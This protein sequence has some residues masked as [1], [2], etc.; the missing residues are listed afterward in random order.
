MR[1]NNAPAPPAVGFDNS[2]VFAPNANLGGDRQ[3]SVLTI[4]LPRLTAE[5]LSIAVRDDHLTFHGERA[6]QALADGRLVCL[7]AATVRRL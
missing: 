7:C 6:R 4:D 5:D 1:W 2:S 3:R